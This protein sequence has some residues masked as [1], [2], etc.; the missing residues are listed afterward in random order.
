MNNWGLKT[1][2][3]SYSISSLVCVAMKTHKVACAKPEL[4]VERL[5]SVKVLNYEYIFGFFLPYESLY[6]KQRRRPFA[7][8]AT[9]MGDGT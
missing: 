4:A 1:F 5:F 8:V 3:L 6:E 9:W 2:N 7:G